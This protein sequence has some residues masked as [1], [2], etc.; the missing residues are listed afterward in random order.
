MKLA[1]TRLAIVLL[2]TSAA[3]I[4]TVVPVAAQTRRPRPVRS[5]P[6]RV[7]PV[8]PP[9]PPP[10]AD[11][12]PIKQSGDAF[13]FG[14]RTIKVPAPDGFEEV[15]A[16]APEFRTIALKIISNPEMELLAVHLPTEWLNELESGVEP[17]GEFYTMTATLKETKQ[18]D[19]TEQDFAKMTSF[20]DKNREQILDVTSPLMRDGCVNCAA[21]SLP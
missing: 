13:R 18:L 2:F 21:I 6:P 10:V 1:T 16:R 19:F 11:D 4:Q 15:T 5:V 8:G 17:D 12:T 3:L 7:G 14:A 9:A 20:A